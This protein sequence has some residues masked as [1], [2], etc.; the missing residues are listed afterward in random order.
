MPQNAAGCL[1]DPPVSEPSAIGT[2]PA[3]TAAA[4]PPDDPPGTSSG[5]TGFFVTPNAL[6]SV[7]EPIANSSRF[8]LPTMT[9]PAAASRSMAVALYGGSQPSRM[10]EEQVVGTPR[11]QR[12]S[13][14]AIGTPASGPGSPPAATV[15]S[16]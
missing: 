1:T 15:A 14:S 10:R 8:V 7:D 6:Y 3:A 11:V 4:D 2:T 13:L 12:L 16:T 5:A 9:A